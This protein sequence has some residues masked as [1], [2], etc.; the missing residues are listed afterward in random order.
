MLRPRLHI[1]GWYCLSLS[2]LTSSASAPMLYDEE[3][4][5]KLSDDCA[6]ST[7]VA[8]SP[9]VIFQFA[10]TSTSI[11]G[12]KDLEKVAVTPPANYQL[13]N[14]L[15]EFISGQDGT[16]FIGIQSGSAR[17]LPVKV[18]GTHINDMLGCSYF[19]SS[20]GHT[21]GTELFS[22]PLQGGQTFTPLTGC[23]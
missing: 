15:L 7:Q 21:S 16:A 14:I 18:A 9:G 17:A 19:E 2:S 12:S 11:G 13:D 4:E 10:T 1:W 5:A 20:M 3:G 23:A 6:N 22:V 8:L